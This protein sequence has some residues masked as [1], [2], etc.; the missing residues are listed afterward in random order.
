MLKSINPPDQTKVN[1]LKPP[2]T[3]EYNESETPLSF[4][5]QFPKVS[6]SGSVKRHLLTPTNILALQHTIGNRAVSRLLAKKPAKKSASPIQRQLKE[7][8][9]KSFMEWVE[10]QIKDQI[11]KLPPDPGAKLLSEEQAK[12]TFETFVSK[13]TLYWR[14]IAK[15]IL[16]SAN[17]L[18]DAKERFTA[19]RVMSATEH[20]EFTEWVIS[21]T[22]GKKLTSGD[23]GMIEQASLTSPTLAL[24]KR[25]ANAIIQFSAS[26]PMTLTKQAKVSDRPSLNEWLMKDEE[27]VTLKQ[28]AQPGVTMNNSATASK[29]D[30]QHILWSAGAA[31]CVIVAAY[32]GEK[33]FLWHSTALHLNDPKDLLGVLDHAVGKG[34]VVY[35]ASQKLA[36][37][38]TKIKISKAIEAEF[39]LGGVYTTSSLATTART[40][41]VKALFNH[42]ELA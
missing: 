33:A 19:G 32:N 8:D 21:Q 3:F 40:G 20:Q 31:D 1:N 11:S 25:K 22:T 12:E 37:E 28:S 34:A 26:N 5:E 9:E 2:A 29:G 24:A 14:T 10:E 15:N 27:A 38:P 36:D 30:K 41:S 4:N 17:E 16:A 39:K 13:Q 35:L 23:L 7:E 6:K 18:E 42:Q